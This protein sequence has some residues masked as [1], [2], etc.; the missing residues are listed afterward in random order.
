MG[1]LLD[2]LKRKAHPDCIFCDVTPEK[3]FNVVAQDD[4]FVAFHDR[5]PASKVHV[6]VIPKDHHRMRFDRASA[7]CL[8]R[9][10][11]SFFPERLV[12]LAANVLTRS[13]N[14]GFH[15]P[16]FNSINHL[17]LHV[18]VLPYRSTIRKLK[19]RIA[20]GHGSRTKGFS[21]F[22]TLRQ[23]IAILEKGGRVGVLPC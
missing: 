3:G 14:L 21:W 4:K 6:L 16:P 8:N 5:N 7:S 11:E 18:Q 10:S 2:A 9:R 17:H 13:W 22:A 19:Y 20:D 12:R 23:A 1:N 15:I